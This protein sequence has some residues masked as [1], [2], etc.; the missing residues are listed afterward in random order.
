MNDLDQLTLSGDPLEKAIIRL[1]MDDLQAVLS[2]YSQIWAKYVVPA[3]IQA[4]EFVDPFLLKFAASH[5][6]ALVRLFNARE[7]RR[8]ISDLCA[9]SGP[10]EDGEV[11]LKLQASTAAFWWSLGATVDNLGKALEQ[12]PGSTLKKRDAGIELLGKGNDYIDF[13][14]A[15]RTQLIHSR[16]VPIGT[17]AGYPVSDP[18]YLDGK[19]RS[20]LPAETNWSEDFNSPVDLD[21]SYGRWWDEAVRAL[22]TAWWASRAFLD[23]V[24][25]PQQTNKSAA[26]EKEISE[27]FEKVRGPVIRTDTSRA[28]WLSIDS[29]GPGAS[30]C[31]PRRNW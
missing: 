11:L 7:F 12:F 17:E 4:G 10:Q 13:I 5:Y 25:K 26:A 20:V 15:R 18:S 6:T 21:T 24:R 8:S 3:R 19:N 28:S 9:Q 2:P 31:P 14:Y 27:Y 23:D 1:A 30:G 22:E 29:G 16:L